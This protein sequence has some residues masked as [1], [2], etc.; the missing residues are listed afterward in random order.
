[1]STQIKRE[2]VQR[3]AVSVGGAVVVVWVP[4]F[5]VP[6][7]GLAMIGGIAVVGIQASV[8]QT[9]ASAAMAGC[10]RV[11]GWGGLFRQDLEAPDFVVHNS[12]PLP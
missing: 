3:S 5:H 11:L 8:F 1:M 4:V 12:L 10:R 9:V 7:A 6:K 2:D